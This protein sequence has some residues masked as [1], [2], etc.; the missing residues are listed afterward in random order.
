MAIASVTNTA[1]LECT[2]TKKC[3]NKCKKKIN[4]TMTSLSEN[5]GMADVLTADHFMNEIIMNNNIYTSHSDDLMYIFRTHLLLY[6]N[7]HATVYL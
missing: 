1:A 5:D 2:I 6:Y 4:M 7:R 3:N